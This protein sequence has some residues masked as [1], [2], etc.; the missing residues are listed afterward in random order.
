MTTTVTH[1]GLDAV[2]SP[3]LRL[4][5]RMLTVGMSSTNLAARLQVDPKT[6]ERWI[7]PGRNPHPAIAH[8]AAALLGVEVTYLWPTIY[9]RRA[10]PIAASDELVALYPGRAAVPDTL[11]ARLLTNATRRIDIIADLVLADL[12][13]DLGDLLTTKASHGLPVRVVLSDPTG[14]TNPADTAR[15]ALAEAIYTPLAQHGVTVRRY[16]GILATTILR[17]DDDLLVRTAIDACPTALAPVLHLRSLTGGPLSR[18]YLTSL[19]AITDTTTPITH[20]LR[21]VA[22]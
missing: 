11:W 9:A 17:A 14:H 15:A 18:L 12:V 19:D 2:R 20:R 22:A 10:T 21:A 16:P 3:N 13:P 7:N 1:A 8:R 4:R 5:E 6:V